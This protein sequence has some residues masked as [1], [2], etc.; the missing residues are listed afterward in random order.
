LSEMNPWLSLI[1]KVCWI[2][3]R[4]LEKRKAENSQKFY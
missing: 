2:M 4:G 1:S 3:R